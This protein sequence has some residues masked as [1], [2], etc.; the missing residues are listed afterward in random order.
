MI[1]D[2][3]NFHAFDDLAEDLM[4][5]SPDELPE[6]VFVEP[7]YQD[8]PPIWVMLPMNMPPLVSAMGRSFSCRCTIRS[9]IARSGRM[10]S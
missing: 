8:A 9:P 7:T 5:S 10:H 3:D 1:L 6:V 4:N 2:W